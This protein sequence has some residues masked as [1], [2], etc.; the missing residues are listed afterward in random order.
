MPC[1]LSLDY[2]W[3][4][5]VRPKDE[6]VTDKEF[7]ALLRGAVGEVRAT[8]EDLAKVEQNE[9]IASL[10]SKVVELELIAFNRKCSMR[11]KIEFLSQLHSEL[12]AV[13][14]ASLSLA[15]LKLS[16]CALAALKTM[17]FGTLWMRISS[18]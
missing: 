4:C 7:V 18:I 17:L 15:V 6:V 13:C 8:W 12:D 11:S 16:R 1:C 5:E 3:L 2:Q 10:Q 14:A 9:K